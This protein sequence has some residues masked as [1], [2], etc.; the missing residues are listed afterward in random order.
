MAESPAALGAEDFVRA[1]LSIMMVLLP[2]RRRASLSA[3]TASA[4]APAA[5][6]RR[7]EPASARERAS[8]LARAL[9]HLARPRASRPLIAHAQL[10]PSMRHD[11]KTDPSATFVA[12]RRALSAR[13]ADGDG[14]RQLIVQPR[15]DSAES[16]VNRVG[17]DTYVQTALLILIFLALKQSMPF[18]EIDCNLVLRHFW[19]LA[20]LS[21]DHLDIR[22]GMELDQDQALFHRTLGVGVHLTGLLPVK[23]WKVRARDIRARA[24]A[25]ALFRMR[26]GVFCMMWTVCLF[27]NA[28]S[29]THAPFFRMI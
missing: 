5:E 4:T 19:E 24:L 18:E 8:S 26:S 29:N 13:L 2:V 10:D 28:F 22:F 9:I 1:C 21:P 6:R 16:A 20:V 17:E 25:R 27:K 12:L 23:F 15:R 14:L 7:C 3:P 11:P